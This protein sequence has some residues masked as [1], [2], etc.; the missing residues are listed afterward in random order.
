[1]NH[2]RAEQVKAIVDAQEGWVGY[3][4]QLRHTSGYHVA[5][6]WQHQWFFYLTRWPSHTDDVQGYVLRKMASWQRYK[7]A[8]AQSRQRE[9]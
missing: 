9:V 4:E 6:E 7:A 8:L 1:M 3:I 5:A 2:E